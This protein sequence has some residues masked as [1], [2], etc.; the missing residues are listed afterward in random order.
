MFFEEVIKSALDQERK[1]QPDRPLEPLHRL[2]VYLKDT[3]NV[4]GTDASIRLAYFTFDP[5]TTLSPFTEL[6]ESLWG[7][8]LYCKIN[9]PQT[10]MTVDTHNNIFWP[11]LRSSQYCSHSGWFNTRGGTAHRPTRKHSEICY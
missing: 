6:L 10:L 11:H 9:V 7:V 5:P 1:P 4:P 3:Y 8:V 2:P